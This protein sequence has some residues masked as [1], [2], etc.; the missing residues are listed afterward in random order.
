M[1]GAVDIIIIFGPGWGPSQSR[2]KSLVAMHPIVLQ[3][4]I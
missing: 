4:A 1:N 3:R 2:H